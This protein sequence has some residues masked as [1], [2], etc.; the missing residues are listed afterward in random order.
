MWRN[1]RY[2]PVLIY[3]HAFMHQLRVSLL[4]CEAF[5]PPFLA[6]MSQSLALKS[7]T[8]ALALRRLQCQRQRAYMTVPV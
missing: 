7:N 5:I 4:V 3:T 2:T 6:P 1:G 8:G